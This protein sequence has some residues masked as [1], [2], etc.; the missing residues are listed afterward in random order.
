LAQ[1]AEQRIKEMSVSNW[2]IFS[3]TKKLA[4]AAEQRIKEMSVSHLDRNDTYLD[5][6]HDFSES[7]Q[8]DVGVK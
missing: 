1:V 6:C 5:G 2:T 3:F 4:Q 7:V 8:A